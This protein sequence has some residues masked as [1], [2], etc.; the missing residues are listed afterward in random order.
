MALLAE[1]IPAAEALEWGLVNRVVADEELLDAAPARS[2]RGSRPGRRSPTR[3]ASALLNAAAYPDLAAQLDREAVAQQGCAESEDFGIGVMGFLTK[4]TR[5]VQ[6]Q[7]RS[8]RRRPAR[9]SHG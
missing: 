6:G 5:G 9:A 2:P 1:K 4:Q 3:P 8:R 7:L